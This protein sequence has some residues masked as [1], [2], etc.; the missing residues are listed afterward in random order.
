M[1]QSLPDLAQH[2][3]EATAEAHTDAE[4]S[5]FVRMFM[6]GELDRGT[7]QH[8]LVA[9]R[10]IYA[11]LERNLAANQNQPALRALNFSE[12]PRL[13]AIQA[14]L[15]FFETPAEIQ[16][17]AA[18][19]AYAEHLDRLGG[20]DPVRLVAHAYVR[21]LGALSGG[22]A[23]AKAVSRTFALADERGVAFYNFPE[24]ENLNE[25]KNV[26]RATLNHLAITPEEH[27]AI[28]EEAKL[29]F[30]MNGRV[31]ES[32]SPEQLRTGEA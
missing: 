4:R 14:D 22:Q 13:S 29:A 11:A 27:L 7:Y 30:Q 31:F 12:L 9:L 3:R 8:Y 5:G 25:F 17:T 21:Y 24:I 23:L 32:L 1:N 16:P 26:Y 6:K 19:C 10:E 2:L 20:A 28:V 18:A 15:R